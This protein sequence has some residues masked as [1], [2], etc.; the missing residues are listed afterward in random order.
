MIQ[1][2]VKPK[3]ASLLIFT[4]AVLMAGCSG[5]KSKD[6]ATKA[7]NQGLKRELVMIPISLGRVGDKCGNEPAF[8]TTKD[9]TAQT[10]YHSLQKAGLITIAT[11][12]PEF[13]RVELVDPKPSVVEALKKAQHRV[14]DGC[15]SVGF[16]FTVAAKAVADIMKI[17]EITSQK[18]EAE[19]TWKWVLY[20]AGVKLVDKLSQ[21]ELIEVNAN[22]EDAHRHYRPDPTFN[23]ADMVQS[24]T[25]HPGRKMLKKSGDGWVLD[26]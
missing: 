26:E 2:N 3:V 7:I 19:Y 18:A 15:D 10:N 20:P 23:L 17:H 22:L 6:A 25:P 16:S 12:G 13:W 11:D 9:L 1:K 4:F 14:I 21:P 8:V 24:S 5:G